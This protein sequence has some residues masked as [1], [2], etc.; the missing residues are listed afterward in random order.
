MQRFG[1]IQWKQPFF[2]GCFRFQVGK[3]IP[4]TNIAIT[5]YDHHQAFRVF[6][7]LE[8][9]WWMGGTVGFLTNKNTEVTCNISC[10]TTVFIKI[11]CK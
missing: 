3:V 11:P 10:S 2:N 4:K 9:G 7:Y 1:L 5:M 8:I 6:G